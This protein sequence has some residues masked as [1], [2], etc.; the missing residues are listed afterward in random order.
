MGANTA[1]VC[2][3][4]DAYRVIYLLLFFN[5]DALIDASGAS[6]MSVEATM[7][8]AVFVGVLILVL[9]GLLVMAVVTALE[10]DV[11]ET[12]LRSYWEPKMAFVL[13]AYDVGGF[14]CCYHQAQERYSFQP[15]S[16][17]DRYT[18]QLARAWD[19][20]ML[21][22]SPTK[23][24]FSAEPTAADAS[25]TPDRQNK[26]WYTK[27]A[28]AA[29]ASRQQGSFSSF[30]A[31]LAWPLWIVSIILVPIWL[32]LGFL[33]LGWLW[34]PQVRRWLFQ[35]KG[36]YNVMGRHRGHHGG[37][38][39]GGGDVVG[40]TMEYT[41]TQLSGMRTEMNNIKTMS[42]EQSGNIE[43]EIRELKELLYLA[44]KEE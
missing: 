8:V 42:Y 11:Y 26:L 36:F 7:L 2:T 29:A 39:D 16:C 32:L 4:Q 31:I 22:L 14:F 28:Q 41:S 5:N 38:S 17:E 15:S 24:S 20:V 13:S 30:Q 10:S 25:A 6:Q 21:S 35:P 43:R 1:P 33:T 19:L 18:M 23:P 12:A 40:A 27:T 9:L 37:S 34:P 44:M 3:A